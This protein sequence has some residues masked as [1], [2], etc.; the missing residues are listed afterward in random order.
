M[1]GRRGIV[2]AVAIAVCVA[3]PARAE[4][5][6]VCAVTSGDPA[7]ARTLADRLDSVGIATGGGEGCTRVR[8]EARGE[9]LHLTIV[10]RFERSTEREVA[11]AA[12]AA[13][14]VESWTLQEVEQGPELAAP[15][16]APV[17]AIDRA[18]VV[19][20]VAAAPAFRGV[21]VRVES[22]LGSDGGGWIGGSAGGCARAGPVCVGALARAAADADP[23]DHTSRWEAAALASVDLPLAIDRLAIVPG[24]AIGGAWTRVS[25]QHRD[26]HDAP[27]TVARDAG[28]LRVEGRLAAVWRLRRPLAVEAALSADAA[29]LRSET[30]ATARATFRAAL[31]IRIEVP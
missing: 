11:D 24:M 20:P 19:P 25:T 6:P 10:D 18:V 30:S 17:S 16:L 29:A 13:A 27:F 7:L 3:A 8:V 26:E 15:P 5:P 31:G 9:R 28:S 2:A 1:S 4:S 22:A 12:T 21:S 14:I 23:P